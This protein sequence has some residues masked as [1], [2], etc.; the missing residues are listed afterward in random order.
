MSLDDKFKQAYQMMQAASRLLFVTH[1]R[2]DGDALSSL[3]ALRLVAKHLGKDSLAFSQS[4]NG[5]L[6]DYLPG[7]DE[8]DENITALRKRGNFTDGLIER[9]DLIIV[10]DCGALA[11]T[12]LSSE[13]HAFKEA[14]GKIIE[15]DH[16]PHIDDYADLE[17]REPLKSS[18]A[19]LIY[20][21]IM[22]NKVPF[23]KE[24]ADCVLTGILTDTGNFLYPSATDATMKAAS[25]AL[26]AGAHYSKIVSYTLGNK[27]MAMVKMWGVAL[28][29]LQL[30]T[31]YQM[32]ITVISR[33][34]INA[35]LGEVDID[36]A[37]ESELFSGLAGFL[38]NLAGAKAVLLLYE[39]RNGMIRGSLRSTA[40]G[41]YVDRLARAL[42]G[43]GHERASGFAFPGK[44]IKKGKKWIVIN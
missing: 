16:H 13:L 1:L 3:C 29:R 22:A 32:A 18:S 39:D 4:K 26:E 14:G 15:F 21:F 25:A 43:G 12:A 37:A 27:D 34:D 19:E 35:I 24:M 38:S 7:F 31:R 9:F 28:E 33:D 44:L 17:I 2:P 5:E 6:F 40:N 30:N 41:M 36:V 11:R 20:D 42:G 10:S 23:T 8:I